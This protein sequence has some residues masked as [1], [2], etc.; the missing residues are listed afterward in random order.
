M[1]LLEVRDLHVA[2]GELEV[3]R[4]VSLSIEPGEIIT[5]LGSNGA[6]KSTMLRSL[7]GLIRRTAGSIQFA[8]AIFA[9][10]PPMI[11]CTSCR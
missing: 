2:Y 11:V 8:A 4:G 6:G 7:S 10:Y 5:I 1:S 9:T 3:V